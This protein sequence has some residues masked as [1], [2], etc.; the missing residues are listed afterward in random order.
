LYAAIAA[1]LIHLVCNPH[2]GF[3]GD[4]LYF[5]VC[6]QHPQWNYVDQPPIAPLLAAGCASALRGSGH[7]CDL[8]GCNRVWWSGLRPT[9]VSDCG[10]LPPGLDGFRDEGLARH[11]RP[12]FLAPYRIVDR[13][14]DERSEP[15]TVGCNRRADGSVHTEQI[16]HFVFRGRIADGASTHAGK[17][18]S[19][20]VVVHSWGSDFRRDRAAGVPVA[21]AL[22]IPD[23]R[24]VACGP[25][26]QERHRWATGLSRT[27]VLDQRLAGGVL[28][29]RTGL[30]VLA[31]T[32]T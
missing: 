24:T 12:L 30:A 23:A 15:A 19:V 14:L 22:W 9:P 6:G 5:I 32:L 27:T 31:T 7:L 2:Y 16:Q 8:P 25:A 4:E 21:G 1:F 29:Y 26:R 3:F 11:G 28:D 17:A 20:F 13:A 10:F 18:D